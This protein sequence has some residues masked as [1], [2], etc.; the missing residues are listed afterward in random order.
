MLSEHSN[1]FNALLFS[2]IEQEFGLCVP[3][4]LCSLTVQVTFQ[5]S[6]RVLVVYLH[7]FCFR[8]Y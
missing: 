5:I 6:S 2:S 3:F 7:M 1:A 8:G 4:A